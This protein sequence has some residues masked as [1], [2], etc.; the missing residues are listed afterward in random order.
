M[1]SAVIEN[2]NLPGPPNSFPF[3]EPT[4]RD[5]V[6]ANIA[7]RPITFGILRI[8]MAFD[9][10]AANVIVAVTTDDALGECEVKLHPMAITRLVIIK[11]NPGP[12]GIML[13]AHKG[14]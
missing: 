4:I 11:T 2:S 8:I 14:A 9:E 10:E 12:G 5:V 3:A 13:G 7:L 6:R 1:K